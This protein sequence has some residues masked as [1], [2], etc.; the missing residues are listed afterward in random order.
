MSENGRH[1]ATGD[2]HP[3]WTPDGEQVAFESH[4]AG[5]ASRIYRKA[6]EN[7]TS[8]AKPLTENFSVSTGINGYF[9]TEEAERLIKEWI[10][11][12]EQ[13][14]NTAAYF[15]RRGITPHVVLANP[16]L[17]YTE[18]AR[19]A[20]AENIALIQYIVRKNGTADI[21]KIIRG[22]GYALDESAIKTIEKYWSFKPGN[23]QGKPVDMPST[24]RIK[25]RICRYALV[26]SWTM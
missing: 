7:T 16:M 21:C 23:S 22:L 6:S 1:G 14:K 19:K 5:A 12:L 2:F 15:A 4:R 13:R 18:H 8:A 26:A 17:P 3:V 25:F 24:I 20:R 10:D 11:R 9:F